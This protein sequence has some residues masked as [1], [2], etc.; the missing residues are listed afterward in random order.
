MNRLGLEDLHVDYVIVD[1]LRV[2][3]QTFGTIIEAWRDGYT[4]VIA[5][6]TQLTRDEVRALFDH[7]IDTIL[8]PQHYAAWHIPVVS[9]RK[10]LPP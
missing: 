8:D 3:R 5:Q 9:G 4:D 2:P 7:S 10:R 1:T 6:H